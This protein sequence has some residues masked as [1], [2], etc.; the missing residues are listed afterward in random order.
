MPD[1]PSRTGSG[2]GMTELAYLIAV[3]IIDTMQG[4]LKSIAS[5]V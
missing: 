4:F 3:L 5:E 2:T 1:P